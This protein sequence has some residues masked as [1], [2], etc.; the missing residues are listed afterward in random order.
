MYAMMREE[1]ECGKATVGNSNSGSESPLY[2]LKLTD[3]KIL[4]DYKTLLLYIIGLHCVGHI[5]SFKNDLFV[6]INV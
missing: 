1:G 6:W 5:K 4:Q 3:F 2:Y